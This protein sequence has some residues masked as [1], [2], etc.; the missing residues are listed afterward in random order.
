MGW[1]A[2]RA[3]RILGVTAE[4]ARL[5]LVLGLALGHEVALFI[6]RQL[7][8]FGL[9][10]AVALSFVLGGGSGGRRGA[11]SRRGG[12]RVGGK[13][14]ARAHQGGQRQ[15]RDQFHGWYPVGGCVLQRGPFWNRHGEPPMAFKL[16]KRHFAASRAASRRWR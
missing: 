13:R 15:G 2:H 1:V 8:G 12:R 14:G 11:R 3:G 5:L 16:R 10:F 9:L 7:L 4:S 6:T